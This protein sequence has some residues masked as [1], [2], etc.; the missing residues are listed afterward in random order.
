MSSSESPVPGPA[1]SPPAATPGPGVPTSPSE[2][3]VPATAA[4]TGQSSKTAAKPPKTPWTLVEI[5]EYVCSGLAVLMLIGAAA[6][7]LNFLVGSKDDIPKVQTYPE[8]KARGDDFA[9][10]NAYATYEVLRH[11]ALSERRA[12]VLQSSGVLVG[13][14][15]AFIALALLS[16]GA[17]AAPARVVKGDDGKGDGV[18]G[19]DG[20][21]AG[22]LPGI[23]ALICATVIVTVSSSDGRPAAPGAPAYGIPTAGF[24]PPGYAAAE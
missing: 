7:V 6:V 9:R 11:Q 15:V 17:R 5:G 8:S 12:S 19:W 18:T 24:A 20:R 1:A 13:V 2:S 3:V 14:A 23:V 21:L 10:S 22:V 4:T 16:K